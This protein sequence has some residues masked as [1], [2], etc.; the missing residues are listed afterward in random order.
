MNAVTQ[1]TEGLKFTVTGR[2]NGQAGRVF[3][4]GTT[5]TITKLKTVMVGHPCETT[6]VTFEVIEQNLTIRMTGVAELSVFEANT[7][8]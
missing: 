4:K 8:F 2:L 7:S 1:I 3:I 6:T 5:G